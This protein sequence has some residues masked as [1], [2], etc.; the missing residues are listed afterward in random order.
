VTG[1]RAG[2]EGCSRATPENRPRQWSTVP[3]QG[4]RDIAKRTLRGILSD[5]G[6]TI[7]QLAP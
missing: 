6:M 5:V 3:V 4:N 7:D 2:I 1:R